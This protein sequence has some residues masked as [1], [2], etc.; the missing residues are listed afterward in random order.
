MEKQRNEK[1]KN[2]F[3]EGW[4]NERGMGKDEDEETMEGNIE[5]RM[6]K[7]IREG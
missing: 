6:K 2:G 1:G 7:K 3:L 4:N 5:G